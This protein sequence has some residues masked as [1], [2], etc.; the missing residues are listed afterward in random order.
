MNSSPRVRFAPSP[1]GHLHIGNARTAILNWLFARHSGGIFILRIEDTDLERSTK[2]SEI[3]IYQD[4]R[5]LGLNWDEGPDVGGPVGPYRQ[6]ER[7]KIYREHAERLI[8]SGHAYYCY[9][10][11]EEL[12]ARREAA[13]KNGQLPRYDGRCRHLT[14]AERAIKE[15]AGRKPVVRFAMPDKDVSFDDLVKGRLTFPPDAL[16]DFVLLR[17][18]GLP[19]YNYAVVV[20]DHLMQISHVIRGDDHVSNTPKQ[21]MLYEAFGWSSPQF[22]HIPMILGP[23]RERLSKRHGA[24]SI[25]EYAS[26]GY[27]PDALINFLSLLGWSSETGEEILSRER[28]IKEFDFSRLTRAAAV[29]DVVKLNWMNGVYIRNMNLDE[30]TAAC[31]PYLQKAD[32][33]LPEYETLKKM[34]TLVRDGLEYLSQIVEKLDMFF[35]D[36]V[37]ITDGAAIGMSQ[38]ESAQKVYWSFLRQ[39]DKYDTLTAEVF[40]RLM[41]TVNEETGVM[42]RDLWMPI[43]IALTGQMHGPEL[44]MIV[45]IFG[46]EKCRRFVQKIVE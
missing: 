40:R 5:W 36:E 20:D 14:P 24:T 41:K 15:K 30:L 21:I 27:L 2:E 8:A 9:C 45:E 25:D 6:S 17:S 26:K 23:D 22:C 11:P 19:T 39:L 10:T 46:K 42:G 13:L 34:I 38:T 7:L 31:I 35:V 1:T 4:L 29:F 18:D 37:R 28:L 33:E 12:E 32:R 43:R 16:G 44:P 3:S